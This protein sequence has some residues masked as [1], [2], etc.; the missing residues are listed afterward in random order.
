[1][2]RMKRIG[3]WRFELSAPKDWDIAAQGRSQSVEVFRLA[4]ANYTVRLE[5]SLEKLPFEKAKGAEELLDAYRKNWEKRIEELKK[6]EG[7]ETSLKHVSKDEITVGGHEGLLWAFRIGGALMMAAVWYCEKSERA[8]SL[9]FTPKAAGE[10]GLFHSILGSVKCHYETASERALWSTLLV[11]LHL[12]QTFQLVSAK[13]SA[14]ATYCLFADGDLERY[15][16]MGYSGVA[17][18]VGRK[19]KKGLREWFEKEI[20]KDASKSFKNQLPKIKYSHETE[21]VLSFSGE[22][23]SLTKRGRRILVGSIWIDRKIDRM[24]VASAFYPAY[25]VEEAKSMLSDLV[26]QLGAR[27]V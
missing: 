9:T 2:E 3:W 24:L 15:L 19:Y 6:K 27:E 18:F 11:D 17:S 8:I 26:K 16:L 5:A 10:E 4:D 22:S 13:F 12:P 23:F 21:D 7:I 20:L 25:D 1:M 14:T